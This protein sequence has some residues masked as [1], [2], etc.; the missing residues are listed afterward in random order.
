M[1]RYNYTCYSRLYDEAFILKRALYYMATSRYMYDVSPVWKLGVPI[2]KY[3]PIY[4]GI[5]GRWYIGTYTDEVNLL[6]LSFSHIG[7]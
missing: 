7:R 2:L 5:F 1:F 4:I 6:T 3:V